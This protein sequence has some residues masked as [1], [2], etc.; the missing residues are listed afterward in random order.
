MLADNVKAI[1]FKI[2]CSTTQ[3]QQLLKMQ[4]LTINMILTL[5]FDILA[6]MNTRKQCAVTFEVF[7]LWLCYYTHDVVGIK[8][9]YRNLQKYQ[10]QN[11]P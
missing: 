9:T 7:V 6:A 2:R 11:T 3:V 8:I 10:G 4:Y 5:K 1:N